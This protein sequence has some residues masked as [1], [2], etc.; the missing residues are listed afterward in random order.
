LLVIYEVFLV[1]NKMLSFI[2]RRLCIIKQVHNEFM[3]GLDVIMTGEFYQT[4]LVR[5]SYIFKPKTNTFNTIAL[6]YWLEYV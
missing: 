3:G 2:D 5:D 6:N 4:P 1:G